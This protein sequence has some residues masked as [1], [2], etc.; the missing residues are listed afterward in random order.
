M[1][2]L[3]TRLF[4]GATLL[5]VLLGVAAVAGIAGAVY[6]F[7]IDKGSDVA[8]NVTSCAGGLNSRRL[9][10]GLE[11]AFESASTPG[12]LAV[13]N[14]GQVDGPL[15]SC[16]VA[17]GGLRYRYAVSATRSCAWTAVGSGSGMSIR[18]RFLIGSCKVTA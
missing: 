15:W 16:T 18:Q 1:R 6:K 11:V 5:A 14:C 4:G 13:A 10:I 7:V 8:C 2:K 9:A 17:D 12:T 3:V